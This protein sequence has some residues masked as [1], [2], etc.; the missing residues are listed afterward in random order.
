MGGHPLECAHERRDDGLHR[1]RVLRHESRRRIDHAARIRAAIDRLCPGLGARVRHDVDQ[2]LALHEAHHRVR[3][4][5]GIDFRPARRRN[6]RGGYAGADEGGVV[7]FEP[8]S[9]QHVGGHEVRAGAGRSDSDFQPFQ[10]LRAAIQNRS[11]RDRTEHESGVAAKLRDRDHRLAFGLH[12]DGMVKSSDADVGASANQRLQCARPALHVSDLDRETA[13]LEIAEPFGHGERQIEDRR[14]ATD[15]EPHI[16]RG[17][18][19]SIARAD[20]QQNQE[21]DR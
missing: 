5:D 11:R 4:D 3:A 15:H 7:G 6:R 18:I 2:P 19:L 14:F 20:R 1:A 13:L 21:S 12:L 16:G 10:A 9:H 17:Q 8:A